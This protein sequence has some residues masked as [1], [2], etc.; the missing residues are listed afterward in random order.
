MIAP[1]ISIVLLMMF[2]EITRNM[3]SNLAEKNKYNYLKLHQDGC[4]I[5]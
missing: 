1:A 3:E 4:L 5:K 2:A